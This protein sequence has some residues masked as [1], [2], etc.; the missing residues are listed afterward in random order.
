[1]TTD[2]LIID[3]QKS[4]EES[5]IPEMTDD[6]GFQE[7]MSLFARLENMRR[8]L[9]DALDRVQKRAN[10]MKSHLLEQMVMFGIKNMNVHG[11]SIYSQNKIYVSKKSEENGVTKQMVCDAL[12]EIGR[13][14]MVADGYHSSSLTSL[15][16]EMKSEDGSGVPEQLEK[17]LNITE[18]V[19]LL[20]QKR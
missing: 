16:K 2:P 11:L 7:Q 13:G 12:D 17:L 15:V 9:E 5:F 18:E 3:A 10:G 20:S 14:D 19:L 1:M 6:A 4:I 8:D